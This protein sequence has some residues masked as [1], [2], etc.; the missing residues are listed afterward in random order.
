[1][2]HVRHTSRL[3]YDN[4]KASG[5]LSKRRFEVYQTLF[6]VGPKTAKEIDQCHRKTGAWK[7][8]SELREL[9]VVQE[10]GTTICPVTK[11]RV[12]LWDTTNNYP[13]A[14]GLRTTRKPSSRQTIKALQER[15]A[16][17]EKEVEELRNENMV[18]KTRTANARY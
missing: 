9:G 10:V 1:M 14:G 13:R 11:Q 5:M 7:R 4:I 2:K 8:L 3:T 6:F 17:L 16:G 18:L 15:I 12:I